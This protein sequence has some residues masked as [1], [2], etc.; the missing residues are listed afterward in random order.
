MEETLTFPEIRVLGCLVEKAATTPENYPMTVN[1]VVNA[2]NQKSAR[3]PVVAFDEETV[4]NAL[5]GLRRKHFAY[6]V[7]AEGSRTAKYRYTLEP[8]GPLDSAHRAILCVLMLRGPQTPG[9]LR[10]RS[11]RLHRF[12]SLDDV[13]ETLREL[14]EDFQEPLVTLLPRE[15]GRKER[16]H[17]H[18]LAGEPVQ[19]A[20]TPSK[21]HEHDAENASPAPPGEAETIAALQRRIDAQDA[22]IA[23]LNERLERFKEEFA[24]FRALFE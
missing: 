19:A 16:R 9:E 1:S 7:D 14:R 12:D 22:R 5:D 6:R 2:C 8:L 17:E 20:V 15:S 11:E 24:S 23:D 13:E 4:L 3:S 18:L 10:S 21:P